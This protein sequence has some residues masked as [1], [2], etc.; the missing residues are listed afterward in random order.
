MYVPKNGKDNNAQYYLR[1]NS[2]SETTGKG[3][4]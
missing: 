2:G 1:T 3:R 4:L